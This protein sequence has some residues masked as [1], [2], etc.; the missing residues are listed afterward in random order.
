[1]V[2]FESDLVQLEEV[3]YSQQPDHQE[4]AVNQS[5]NPETMFMEHSAGNLYDDDSSNEIDQL[6]TNRINLLESLGTVQ[7]VLYSAQL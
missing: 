3:H 5:L 6:K 4:P 1:M 2:Q 7:K